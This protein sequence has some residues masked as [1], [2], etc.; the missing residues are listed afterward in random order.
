MQLRPHL[1][2]F[3]A[4]IEA[5]RSTVKIGTSLPNC[6]ICEVGA[7]HRLRRSPPL[8]FIAQSAGQPRLE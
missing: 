1:V 2:I 8:A 5:G 3:F 6:S 4:R 7:T